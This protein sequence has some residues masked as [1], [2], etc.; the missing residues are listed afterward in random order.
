MPLW[1]LID[2]LGQRLLANA[3]RLLGQQHL[4]PHEILQRAHAL[5][6]AS[7]VSYSGADR[8]LLHALRS[9]RASAILAAPLTKQ[10]TAA[11]L[12]CP[13]RAR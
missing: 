9:R 7:D 5:R 4:D 6:H 10:I 3:V 11:R 2:V 1:A 12:G 8:W 13:R